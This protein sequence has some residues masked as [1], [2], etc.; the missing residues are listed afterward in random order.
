MILRIFLATLALVFLILPAQARH[1]H[2]H[3]HVIHDRVNPGHSPSSICAGTTYDN[4][5][6]TH[7]ANG[8][9]QFVPSPLEGRGGAGPRARVRQGGGENNASRVSLRGGYVRICVS[10]HCGTVA[11]AL[12]ENFRGLFQDFVAMGYNIGAPGCLSAGHMAHSLHHSG[13]ACDLFDQVARNVTALHQPPPSVQI[14]VAARHGLTSGCAWRSPD[15]GHFDVSGIGGVG[16]HYARARP[17]RIRL[18]LRR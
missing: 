9:P 8:F 16:R 12:A 1:V 13:S 4:D 17:R 5:G 18:A 6:R 10:G 15:C 3:H 11:A 2:R 14:E 7:C